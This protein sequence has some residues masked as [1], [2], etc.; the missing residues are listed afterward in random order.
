[1]IQI[2]IVA[3]VTLLASFLCSLLEASLYAVTPSQ[4]EVLKKRKVFGARRF[5]KFRE[6]IEEPIAA[7]LTINTVAH[8]VGAAVTG[9]MVGELYGNQA[10]GLFAALFTLAVLL[11]TEIVPK[12]VGVRHAQ[13]LVPF[14]VWPL[15]IMIWI[16]WPVAK[17]S[18]KLMHILVGRAGKHGP[19][20]EEIVM[21]SRMAQR[22][23]TLTLLESRWVENAL[24]LDKVAAHDVMTPRTV[25][26]SLSIDDRTVAD[27]LANPEA[28]SHSRLPAYEAGD[29]DRLIGVLHR[30]DLYDAFADGR[31]DV[32]LRELVR[33][34][35]LVPESMKG[36]VLLDRFIRG[37]RHMV[38]VIDEYGGFEGIVT[39]EDILEC[40]L[41]QEIVDEH[42]EHDDMQEYARRQALQNAST[43]SVAGL[44]GGSMG[45]V[46]EAP[47]AGAAPPV[48]PARRVDADTPEKSEP[49][50]G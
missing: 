34:L 50:A 48:D 27:L 42:D 10:V 30:R 7:I 35:D 12:S 39:L 25:V 16:A 17:P 4:L 11:G 3:S 45:L 40:L 49:K 9:A 2:V 36:P 1:M 28:V 43:G 8:T 14:L 6:D 13:R 38:A 44:M 33:P 15:Q 23:G 26:Q 22:G 19:T 24:G 18:K 41:G 37:K 21:M 31:G 29:Q 5:A 47:S 20:E 32:P 46:Q